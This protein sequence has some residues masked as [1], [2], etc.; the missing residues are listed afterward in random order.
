MAFFLTFV[1]RNQG[2]QIWLVFIMPKGEM[3]ST[4]YSELVRRTQG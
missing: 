3:V 2:G 1:V 4:G